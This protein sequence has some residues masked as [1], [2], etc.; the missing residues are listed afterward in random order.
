MKDAQD[1]IHLMLPF[2]SKFNVLYAEDD[3]ALREHMFDL[4][5][6]LFKSVTCASDGQE[7]FDLIKN[8]Y[9]ILITDINMPNMNGIELIKEVKIKDPNQMILVLSAYNTPQYLIPLLKMG[10]NNYLIKPFDLQRFSMTLLKCVLVIE[11]MKNT[12]EKQKILKEELLHLRKENKELKELLSKD[13]PTVSKK[14]EIKPVENDNKE[15]VDLDKLIE[16]LGID[17]I[18]SAQ[19]LDELI[20]STD[21][22]INK[23][24]NNSQSRSEL[25][26]IGDLYFE[27]S[28]EF[29]SFRLSK[30]LFGKFKRVSF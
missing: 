24:K 28:K 11:D 18:E 21:F 6:S 29:F 25:V 9:D 1:Y 27:L 19:K 15:N 7:A 30:Y 17:T 4:L 12:Q 26:T 2:S 13:K 23:L 10:V 14:I 3:E 16:L 20:E 8:S 5:Q 22:L